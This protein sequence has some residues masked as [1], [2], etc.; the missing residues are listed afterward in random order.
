MKAQIVEI[1]PNTIG[2]EVSDNLIQFSMSC[3]RTS[4]Q[5]IYNLTDL[6]TTNQPFMTK[7][8]MRNRDYRYLSQ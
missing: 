4:K 5:T 2:L 7:I 6:T 1:R 8:S 3:H